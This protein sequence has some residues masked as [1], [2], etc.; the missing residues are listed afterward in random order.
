MAS[1][2]FTAFIAGTVIS[3]GGVIV[4]AI[5]MSP[6][7]MDG[8][9]NA[10]LVRPIFGLVGALMLLGPAITPIVLWQRR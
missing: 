10:S 1:G 2:T 8:S 5:M 6:S 3:A 4:L 7:Y 9:P